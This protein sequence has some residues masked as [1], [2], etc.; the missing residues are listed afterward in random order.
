M[1]ANIHMVAI[2]IHDRKAYLLL[3][4][5]TLGQ[6]LKNKTSLF[7]FENFID[8]EHHYVAAFKGLKLRPCIHC[9]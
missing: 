2:C 3:W 6:N 5:F 7:L 8:V 1:K 9:I 4:F